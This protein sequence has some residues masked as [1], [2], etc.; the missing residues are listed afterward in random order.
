VKRLL[1][2]LLVATGVAEA[3]PRF[4]RPCVIYVQP[5]YRSDRLCEKKQGAPITRLRPGRNGFLH[6][7]T[8]DCDGYVPMACVSE[9]AEEGN[10]RGLSKLGEPEDRDIDSEAVD[11]RTQFQLGPVL[12]LGGLWGKPPGAKSGTSGGSLLG[13][14]QGRIQF[15]QTAKL[16]VS[17]TYQSLSLSRSIDASGSSIA[18]ENPVELTQR[19]KFAGLGLLGGI[20]LGNSNG[21]SVRTSWW[22]DAG[23]EWLAPLAATQT[24]NFGGE[25]SFSTRDKLFLIEG[26]PSGDFR[27][28][29]SLYLLGS[30]QFLYNV[31]SSSGN[32]LLGARLLVA[33]SFGV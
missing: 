9:V 33:L 6:V 31:G 11:N 28:A 21:E 13:G 27:L 24:D 3:V 5:S 15:R 30:L 32:S 1:F 29:K 8:S 23:F 4:S 20:G 10:R 19:V 18:D 7:Q 2:L 12:S 17:I 14:L 22:F 25:I 26:G 16:V